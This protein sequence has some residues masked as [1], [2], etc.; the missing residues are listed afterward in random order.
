[1]SRKDRVATAVEC[2]L[3]LAVRH[4]PPPW[5]L[6]DAAVFATGRLHLWCDWQTLSPPDRL[7]ITR[8][9]RW[10]PEAM[11]DLPFFLE[12][13]CEVLD[14]RVRFRPE[15]GPASAAMECSFVAIK[16]KPID[17]VVQELLHRLQSQTSSVPLRPA[18]APASGQ[19]GVTLRDRRTA[20]SLP[21][22]HLLSPAGS[23]SHWPELKCSGALG[24]ITLGRTELLN[25]ADQLERDRTSSVPYRSRLDHLLGQLEVAPDGKAFG[26]GATLSCG[27]TGLFV[28]PT[29]GGKSILARVLA[30]DLARR[31]IPVA[32]IVPDVKEV[33]REAHRLQGHIDANQWR[34]SVA[35]INSASRMMEKAEEML[36]FSSDDDAHANW[37]IERLAYPC[38]L[39]A[40][41]EPD[42]QCIPGSEPCFRLS[43]QMGKRMRDVRCPFAAGCP[44]FGSFY[45]S[46][47]ANILVV[48]HAAFLVG[49]VPVPIIVDG[50][51]ILKMSV[52]EL[53]FRR[54][55]VVL[56]DEIDALQEKAIGRSSGHLQ[57]SSF[58]RMSPMYKLLDDFKRARAS[59][60]LPLTQRVDRVRSQLYFVNWLIDELTDLMNLDRVRWRPREAMRWSG[61]QDTWLAQRLFGAHPHALKRLDELYEDDPIADSPA[62]MLRAAVALWLARDLEDAKDLAQLR[63]ALMSALAQWPTALATRP[64]L[65]DKTKSRVADGLILRAML[66][67]LER[68][69]SQLRPQLPLLEQHG[70]EAAACVRDAL[71]GYMPWMP[72]PLGPLGRRVFG[73]SFQGHDDEA[74]TIYAQALC[75]DPH[76]LIAG[77]G[78]VSAPAL[79][80]HPRIVIGLSATAFFPGSPRSHVQSPVVIVQPDSTSGVAVEGVTVIDV[81]DQG[82]PVRISGVTAPSKRLERVG[83]LAF[84]LWSQVLGR[85]LG[86][87]REDAATTRRA[88]A[89]LVTGS[90]AETRRAAAALSQ[91]M[92]S[93]TEAD[94]RLRYVVPSGEAGC[95]KDDLRA[96]PPRDIEKFGM[97]DA[98]VLIAPLSVVARGHN[99]VQGEQGERGKSAIASVFV[100]VRPVPPVEDAARMLAHVSYEMST[101]IVPQARL[102]EAL[103]AERRRAEQRLFQI[104]CGVGPFSTMPVDLKHAILCDV[105]V[106]LAQLAGRCRRGGTDVRLYLVDGA[107]HDD[108]V[109]WR[110]LIQQS[111]EIWKREGDLPRMMRMHQAFLRGLAQFAGVEV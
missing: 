48:N 13:A 22:N 85:H 79:S 32:I 82:K 52:M 50:Q 96:I 17:H 60:D 11:A 14:A 97:S 86:G 33:M 53:V 92:G 76:G 30:L 45:R 38:Q 34:L 27:P 21:A 37:A 106:D 99:I 20:F 66:T 54:C 75:G 51:P 18:P 7:I 41:A 63:S 5:R 35:T 15:P 71:L 100:L 78:N 105:L 46:V 26:T 28:A 44:K 61:A 81:E 6:G 2:A 110:H 87:L 49:R 70:I 43:Q 90:Y 91:A 98:D 109:G 42:D 73:F 84:L 104:R 12:Q 40:Y 62:E 19:T 29:G 59:G 95:D 36:R 77:L 111:F 55:G 83:R 80:G 24:A 57:L 10:R 23:T 16:G 56:I 4:L 69:L 8:F 1:M 72:S 88:R 101:G 64:A 93:A 102:A 108:Q 107:F 68:A 47:S 103:R 67:R 94:R 39:S 74:G 58:G 65:E 89:L 3:A 31:G 25:L 9:M